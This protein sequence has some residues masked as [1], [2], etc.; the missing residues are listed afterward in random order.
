MDQSIIPITPAN[1]AAIHDAVSTRLRPRHGRVAQPI[2]STPRSTTILERR[3]QRQALLNAQI[4]PS[5][6]RMPSPYCNPITSSPYVFNH[7]F[8]NNE[9][10]INGDISFE[11]AVFGCQT[12]RQ[13]KHLYKA[14]ESIME[15]NLINTDFEAMDMPNP[16]RPMRVR[17]SDDCDIK[18]PETFFAMFI[19][20]DQFNMLARHTNAYAQSQ[21]TNLPELHGRRKS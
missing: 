15:N 6:V 3:L 8:Y 11:D 12:N 19:G 21:L 4:T 1:P 7:D 2:L 10:I 18:K 9:E 17:L 13:A 20:D 16:P 14:H 5:D